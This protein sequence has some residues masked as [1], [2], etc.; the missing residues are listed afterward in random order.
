[1]TT[2]AGLLLW[3]AR[4]GVVEILIGHMGGPFWAHK[5]DHA[6]SIPK[7]L[8]DVET[9]EELL[10][11]A[12]R[13]FAE[14]MGS[15]APGGESID[16]GSVKSGTKTITV[17]A[18]SGDFD[19]GAAT[20]NTFTMEWP[21]GSGRIQ[22]FPEI[23]RAEWVPLANAERYLTKSQAPLLERLATAISA[24]GETSP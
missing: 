21:R 17:F 10:I 22:E 6:W 12:E 16:L 24:S 1:M 13:E 4:D 19:A 20:S 2:S 11:A 15:A 8:V 23:D 14:E 3:R 7:G 5:S 9:D 18:R